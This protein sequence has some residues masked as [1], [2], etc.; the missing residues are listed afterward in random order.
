MNSTHLNTMTTRMKAGITPVFSLLSKRLSAAALLCVGLALPATA[1]ALGG[2]AAVANPAQSAAV[3]DTTP[4]A[5]PTGLS[6]SFGPAPAPTPAPPPTPAPGGA[7]TSFTLVSASGGTAVVFSLGQVFPKGAV[8]AGQA[9]VLDTAGSQ[10]TPISSWDDGSV[11]HALVAGSTELSANTAKLVSL[12]KGGAAGG[13]ALTEANLIAA[14]PQASVSYGSYGTVNLASLLNTSARVLTEHAGPQYAAFQYIANFP[15][16]AS[17]RAVFYVQLWAA[18]KYRVRVAVENGTAL[19]S[20][21]TKS[22][23]ATVSVAGST[24]FSGSVSMPQGVR[25][26]AVGANSP[27]VTVAHN[28]AYLRGSK[29]VP[30]YGY[31][32]PSSS[33]LAGLTSTYTPMARLDWQQDM[34][35]TGYT[36]GIGLLP[37]WDAVYAATGDAR[38]LLD[39]VAQSRAFGSYSIFYRSNT[40][41]A[42][43]TFSNYP[44]AVNTD[45]ANQESM[46]GNGSNAN[47]WEIAHHPHAGYLAWLMTGERFY[48]EVLQANA[49]T[50]WYT[51]SGE[52][53]TGV[54]KIYTSQTR[55]RAWRYRTISA[56][57]AVSPDG[58]AFKADCKASIMANV[59]QW[60]VEHATPNTPATGLAATYD[61]QDSGAGFQRSLFEHLFLV[62]SIGWSWD[63][64][65]QLSATDKAAFKRVRDYFYKI[66]VGL[67]GR[68]PANGEWSWRRG[69]GLYRSTVGPDSNTLFNTWGEAYKAT[70]NDNLDSTPG[71][72]ITDNYADDQSADAFPEGNWGHL[73]TALSYAVDHGATGAAEGY[74]RIT[75]AS[76]WANNAAKFNNRPQYGVAR[77]N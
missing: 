16:D 60:D 52:G 58:D 72:S 30:N 29:L 55:A 51:D 68:G 34:G 35:T 9:L 54:N 49:W 26:D 45:G 23:T 8:P 19:A 32:S 69:P 2:T 66:P 17:L 46:T 10:V 37:H 50:A 7:L 67:A 56:C 57:A 22:G 27:G 64:E 15:N 75:G 14:A 21:S 12:S 73:V 65:M 53:K 25:W 48:L 11:K 42:F 13:A 74:S 40:T 71:L 70:Y 59:N 63:M 62:A 61:D 31:G 33:V 6:V 77:R 24:Q 4:P 18:G 76:N 36:E 1:F 20:S 44:S 39:S 47:R 41:K 38:G 3:V 5:V 43:P 28:G